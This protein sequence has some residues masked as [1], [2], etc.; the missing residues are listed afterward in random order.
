MRIGILRS[1]GVWDIDSF[2][3]DVAEAAEGG[4]SSYW[5]PNLGVAVDSLMALAIAGRE[6]PG[7][8]LG[9]ASCQSGPA[10]S[11]R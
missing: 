3:T 11:R 10:I 1:S 5:V 9:R 7:I 4:F 6:V 8:E 2:V